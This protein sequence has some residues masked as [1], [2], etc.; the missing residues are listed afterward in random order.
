MKK[1]A[2]NGKLKKFVFGSIVIIIICQ[3]VKKLKSR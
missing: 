2:R 1:I 3:V